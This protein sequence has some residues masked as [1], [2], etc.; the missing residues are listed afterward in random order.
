MLRL[1]A[2]DFKENDTGL[3]H[4]GT[5]IQQ[6]GD[7]GLILQIK[8][9]DGQTVVVSNADWACLP[10]HQAPAQKSWEDESYTGAGVFTSID[11]PQ[12]WGTADF[13]ASDW[14]AAT[15]H[16]ESKDNYDK[17][18]W[19]QSAQLIRGANLQTD[20]TLPCRLTVE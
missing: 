14:P 2:K 10:I 1:T 3:E 20:N 11:A 15:E 8:D 16:S 7:G 6:M 17:I 13:D 19:D 4:I 9:A 5:R 18:S 12:G